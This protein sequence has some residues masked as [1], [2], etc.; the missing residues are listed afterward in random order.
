MKKK[1]L[2]GAFALGL[3]AFSFMPNN[4][5]ASVSTSKWGCASATTKCGVPYHACGNTV[6]EQLD[7]L[8][9]FQDAVC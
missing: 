6:Q 5:E 8:R 9:G 7:N 1:F 2:I 3:G 4:V